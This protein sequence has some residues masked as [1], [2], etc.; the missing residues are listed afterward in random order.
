MISDLLS[1]KICPGG[2][3]EKE[4]RWTIMDFHRVISERTLNPPPLRKQLTNCPEK[5]K[6][7][8]A[9]EKEIKSLKNNK[10]WKSKLT[11]LPP[12]R[13]AI[14]CKWVYKVE[15]NGDG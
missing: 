3:L 14:W 2:V 10:I 8:E 5:A 4:D 15:T 6:W 13:N 12:E 1:L 7:N 11:T 9:M